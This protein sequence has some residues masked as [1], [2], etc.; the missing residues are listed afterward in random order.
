MSFGTL[1]NIINFNRG[2]AALHLKDEDLENNI[3]PYDDWPLNENEK[4]EKSCPVCER[5]WVGDTLRSG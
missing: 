5:I 1:Q 4:G 3:C 2:Q